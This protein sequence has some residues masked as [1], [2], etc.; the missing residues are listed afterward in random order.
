MNNRPAVIAL[1]ATL[2]ALA[3][4][5]S[6]GEGIPDHQLHAQV[7]GVV[8]DL[9]ALGWPPERV[10][11]SVKELAA[12]AGLRPSTHL[13]TVND[14][15]DA[16]D[17]LLAKVVRWSIQ[18]YFADTRQDAMEQSLLVDLGGGTT[19]SQTIGGTPQAD[20]SHESSTL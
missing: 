6:L 18:R 20:S 1:R 2:S 17:A 3:S 14:S 15:L 4:S 13:M 10:I 5:P 9:R 8:D 7:C 12:E 19:G 16:S 11:I